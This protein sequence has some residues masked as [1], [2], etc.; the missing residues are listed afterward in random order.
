MI[1][2]KKIT[3]SAIATQVRKVSNGSC[4]TKEIAVL[5][6]KQ[7]GIPSIRTM[8]VL[9]AFSEIV[10]SQLLEGKSIHVDGLGIL[11]LSISFSD[12]KVVAKRLTITPSSELRK[13]LPTIEFKEITE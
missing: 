2:Y 5:M 11:N 4:T 6:E 10:T 7:I 13:Q 12:G 3:T 1:K 8:S 9:N